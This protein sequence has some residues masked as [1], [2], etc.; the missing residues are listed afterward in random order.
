MARKDSKKSD[1]FTRVADFGRDLRGLG[2]LQTSNIRALKGSKF[3]PAS[4]VR[5][6]DADERAAVIARL[7][8][9]G[10]VK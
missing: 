6:L 4:E 5:K 2:G 1:R 7:R 3:G 9:D 8:A 10:V